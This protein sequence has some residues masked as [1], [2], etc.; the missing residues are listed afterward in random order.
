MC[1]KEHIFL[2]AEIVIQ[3]I[4]FHSINE[5][6][7]RKEIEANSWHIAYLDIN[8]DKYQVKIIIE[9]KQNNNKIPLRNRSRCICNKLSMSISQLTDKT[10]TP[11]KK[12]SLF[13]FNRFVIQNTVS[14]LTITP[15]HSCEAAILHNMKFTHSLLPLWGYLR[16]SCYKWLSDC[17]VGLI[18]MINCL[19]WSLMQIFSKKKIC[20]SQ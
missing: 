19:V 12:N 8:T 16:V 2:P 11:H 1:I 18:N 5:I 3:S 10:H 20:K 17:L 7:R 15:L 4:T 9:Q 14:P 6:D 13:E